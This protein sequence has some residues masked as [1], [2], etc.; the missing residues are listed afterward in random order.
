M[1]DAATAYSTATS[2][3][4]VSILPPTILHDAASN[5]TQVVAEVKADRDSDAVIRYVSGTFQG[6]FLAT[7][8]AVEQVERPAVDLGIQ[9][10]DHIG[11]SVGDERSTMSYLAAATGVPLHVGFCHKLS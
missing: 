5:T 8:E 4:A 2:S 6:P 11:M 1:E 7:F 9:R 3:G 10:V